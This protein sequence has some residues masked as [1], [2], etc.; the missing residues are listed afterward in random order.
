MYGMLFAVFPMRHR[1]RLLP[2]A[3]LANRPPL[4]GDLR[5]EEIRDETLMR[6]VR[7]ARVLDFSRPRAPA[8]L[9][10][11]FEP[12]VVAM[13][14]QAFTLSGVERIGDACYGQSWLV[15]GPNHARDAVGVGASFRPVRRIDV[16]GER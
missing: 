13:S 2:R 12:Q 15:R 3:E 4:V 16:P 9:A 10:E 5:I 1:G 7:T 6:Y 11:L 14:P 8:V